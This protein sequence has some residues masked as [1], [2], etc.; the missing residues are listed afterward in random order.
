MQPRLE[1]PPLFNIGMPGALKLC[2]TPVRG[3]QTT[4]TTTCPDPPTPTPPPHPASWRTRGS[5]LAELRPAFLP[6]PLSHGSGLDRQLLAP[7]RLACSAQLGSETQFPRPPAPRW[8]TS[9]PPIGSSDPGWDP[10][11]GPPARSPPGSSPLHC[12]SSSS[13]YI[14]RQPPASSLGTL[15]PRPGASCLSFSPVSPGRA[16]S[17]LRGPLL[18][19]RVLTPISF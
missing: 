14:L 3:S 10:A 6:S 16:H 7:P 15:P 13:L 18:Q 5:G 19:A 11:R 2:P 4:S 1:I 17:A 8:L 12:S 9:A